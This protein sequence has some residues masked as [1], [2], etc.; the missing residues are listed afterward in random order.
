[1]KTT[2]SLRR[3]FFLAFFLAPSLVT[4]SQIP[5]GYYDGTAGLT[6]DTLRQALHLIIKNHQPQT[7]ASLW[8]HFLRTD[9]K[10]GGEVWDIY[11]DIPGGTPAYT[12]TFVTNQ[13]G[14]YSKEGDCYN[15]EHSVPASWFS[16]AQPV[17][18]DL[19]H[20]YPTDGFVNGKR[21]NYPFGEVNTTTWTSS[22][23]SRL[24][25]MNKYGYQGTVFE[26][27]DSFKG[28]LARTY[29]YM[30]VRYLDVMPAW[31]SDMF[32][33]D[34]LA[35][36]TRQ[37]LLAWHSLDP[38]SS[39]EIARN[40][41]IFLIQGNRNPFIDHPGW[42][43]A[44]WDTPDGNGQEFQRLPEISFTMT[45]GHEI[46]VSNPQNLKYNL[47]VYAMNGQLLTESTGTQTNNHHSVPGGQGMVVAVIR[48]HDTVIARRL[49][50]H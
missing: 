13:C 14:N 1:M 9:K 32:A 4:L 27:I 44:I 10:P 40:D 47:K 25:N 46:I 28:D 48:T 37:L 22:N 15:R 2:D 36:W 21:S 26:P 16:N 49:L 35:P 38:V 7:Y 33:G 41:S 34:S 39:K 24:G 29:L 30:A 19:F 50:K 6:G 23:G 5:A 11:S 42:V 18:T 20:L 12:Y 31:N 17:Y 43:A 45:G 3:F 8:T